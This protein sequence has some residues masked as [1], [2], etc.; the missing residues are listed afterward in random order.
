MTLNKCIHIDWYGK[1]NR[2]TLVHINVYLFQERKCPILHQPPHYIYIYIYVT[3]DLMAKQKQTDPNAISALLVSIII[4]YI[5]TNT[6]IIAI[7]KVIPDTYRN[8]P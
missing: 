6:A 8:I 2:Q 5:T 1:Y 4:S 3:V 7:D